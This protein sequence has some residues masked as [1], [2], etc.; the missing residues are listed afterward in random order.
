MEAS[1]FDKFL[2]A[3]HR[4]LPA[5]ALGRLVYRLSRSERPWLKNTL[6]RGFSALF[7]VDTGEALI[8]EPEGYASFNAFFTRKLRPGARPVNPDKAALLSPADG[9]IAQA[10]NAAAGSLLQ[11]KGMHFSAATLLGDAAL[12]E[13]LADAPFLTVY[14][15][16]YNYH[17]VHMPC[18]GQLLRS[19]FIP[20]RLYS[21]NARTTATIPDLY[22][23]NERLVCEFTTP[24]GPCAVVLV[25]AINVASITTAWEGEILPPANGGIVLRDY[26]AGEPV[27]LNQG[28][29]L[30]HF[31]MGSTVVVLGPPGTCQ[32]QANCVSGQAVQAGEPLGRF[33]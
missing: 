14:L 13:A 11:A 7:K 16:P 27:T 2:V 10:G 31:N 19:R 6:I 24:R 18:D 20:G 33:A 25:G 1:V 15:A 29:Y 30:G 8:S 5:R 3:L 22:A 21:V 26:S 17:R 12:A 23:V 4:L 9:T 32:W 28:D